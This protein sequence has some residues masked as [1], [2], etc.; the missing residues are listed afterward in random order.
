MAGT[1]RFIN[2]GS[3]EKALLSAFREWSENDVNDKYWREKFE[4]PWPYPGPPT[5][6]KSKPPAG[7]PRDILDTEE[8]YES[9][10]RSYKYEA[11]PNG[12][13]AD[14]HWDATNSSGE[15]YAWFVHEGQGPYARVAR[16]WT[17]EMASEWL[18]EQS[19]IKRDL[20][21]AVDRNLNG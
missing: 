4:E 11:G 17:D 12:A 7:N 19:E 20:E 1:A 13:R 15:E 2:M 6:R 3:V 8:L 18:F 9:G 16:P 10:V 5:I 21:Q 14:W